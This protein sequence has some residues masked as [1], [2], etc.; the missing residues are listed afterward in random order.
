METRHVNLNLEP[1]FK[2][3]ERLI[4]E[5]PAPTMTAQE[6]DASIS[7]LSEIAEVLP[8]DKDAG[9][10]ILQEIGGPVLVFVNRRIT[11]QRIAENLIKKSQ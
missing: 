2:V 9:Q 5:T 1:L 4:C 6:V 10:K 3:L 8:L 11:T 7:V